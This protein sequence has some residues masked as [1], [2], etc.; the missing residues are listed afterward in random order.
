MK[1]III[2]GII[3]LDVYDS[4]IRSQLEA[5]NNDEITVEIG[6]P[7]GFIFQGLSIFNLIRDYSRNKNKVTTKLI[8][9][10][11]S[12]ASY[13]A[14]AGDKVQAE[15]NSVFMVHN[16]QMLIQGDYRALQKASD[17]TERLADLL[18]NTYENKCGKSK[19][20]V[21]QMMDDETYF[22]GEEAKQVGFVD[23]I[24]KSKNP[25]NEAKEDIITIAQARI[26]SC[27]EMME[28]SE[29]VKSDLSKAAALLDLDS[30]KNNVNIENEIK[31]NTNINKTEINNNK[32]QEEKKNMTKE[33]LK[34][35]SPDLYNEIFNLGVESVSVKL[36][37]IKAHLQYKDVA[38]ERVFTAIEKEESFDMISQ[39]EYG[40][41]QMNKTLK[42]AREEDDPK[43]LNTKNDNTSITEEDTEKAY[44]K[45]QAMYG[46]KK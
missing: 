29:K 8:G 21:R 6:S 3:G 15:D 19:K 46:G 42:I 39:A 35:Q 44:Q 26:K 28:H 2:E 45:F 17:T 38:P 1:T 30:I 22:F 34:A 37:N 4:M 32:I 12:M 43:A 10:A 18:A 14:L 36:K 11:A 41:L 40:K 13:I 25:R 5:A 9:L 24:I 33:E 20:K 31:N 27:F 16:P 7:G 23:E